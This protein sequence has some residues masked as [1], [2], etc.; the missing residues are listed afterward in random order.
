MKNARK[1]KFKL[2]FPGLAYEKHTKKPS[3]ILLLILFG[4]DY[5]SLNAFFQWAAFIKFSQGKTYW[6]DNGCINSVSCSKRG[7]YT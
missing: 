5:S 2:Q 7:T 1:F 4:L 6:I 3:P